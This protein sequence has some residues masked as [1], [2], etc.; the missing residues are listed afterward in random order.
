M[1]PPA[2][3]QPPSGSL[4]HRGENCSREP[5]SPLPSGRPTWAGWTHHPISTWGGEPQLVPRFPGNQVRGTEGPRADAPPLEGSPPGGGWTP[6]RVPSP[7]TM[8]FLPDLPPSSLVGLSSRGRATS[9]PASVAPWRLCSRPQTSP[10]WRPPAR[11][12]RV[13][14][15]LPPQPKQ[16][17][18]IVTPLNPHKSAEEP[19]PRISLVPRCGD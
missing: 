7:P 17:V 4:V 18:A 19:G 1:E 3:A 5:R 10:S 6:Q 11:V 12:S 2:K 9:S 14:I 16:Q 8:T 13:F 15:Q